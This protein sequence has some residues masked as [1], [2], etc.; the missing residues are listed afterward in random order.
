MRRAYFPQG[1]VSAMAGSEGRASTESLCAVHR[2]VVVPWELEGD[3]RE[4]LGEILSSLRRGCCR[5][6]VERRRDGQPRCKVALSYEDAQAS[7]PDMFDSDGYL[8]TLCPGHAEAVLRLFV[9]GHVCTGPHCGDAASGERALPQLGVKR[10]G[11]RVFCARCWALV[12]RRGGVAKTPKKPLRLAMV[13]E[14]EEDDELDASEASGSTVFVAPVAAHGAVDVAD[15]LLDEMSALTLSDGSSVVGGRGA[16]DA[17][18]AGGAREAVAAA[19]AADGGGAQPASEATAVGEPMPTGL[20]RSMSEVD[21]MSFVDPFAG[22]DGGAFD[23]WRGP[24]T[25][26][27]G[28]GINAGMATTESSPSVAGAALEAADLFTVEQTVGDGTLPAHPDSGAIEELSEVGHDEVS[29]VESDI[30]TAAGT[31]SPP[32][33]PPRRLRPTSSTRC[34]RP[35]CPCTARALDVDVDG[36]VLRVHDFCCRTCATSRACAQNYHRRALVTVVRP[37]APP[38]APPPLVDVGLTAQVETLAQLVARLAEKVD[39]IAVAGAKGSEDLVENAAPP[40]VEDVPVAEPPVVAPAEAQVKLVTLPAAQATATPPKF[41][42]MSPAQ[43]DVAMRSVEQAR[44]DAADAMAAV[45][46]LKGA[47]DLAHEE[48]DPAERLEKLVDLVQN[49]EVDDARVARQLTEKFMEEAER[50]SAASKVVEIPEAD[51]QH[52]MFQSKEEQQM[53]RLAKATNVPEPVVMAPVGSRDDSLLN[54]EP[55]AWL[56]VE[57]EVTRADVEG[58]LKLVEP[59]ARRELGESV[60]EHVLSARCHEVAAEALGVSLS[61]VEEALRSVA[62]SAPA[63]GISMVVSERE[64]VEV[65]ESGEK[66]AANVLS[67]AVAENWVGSMFQAPAERP[68][69]PVE[70]RLEGGIAQLFRLGAPSRSIPSSVSSISAPSSAAP[71]PGARDRFGV[72]LGGGSWTSESVV[73]S[74]PTY[75]EGPSY[76]QVVADEHVG[77]PPPSTTAEIEQVIDHRLHTR[78]VESAENR[79]ITMDV[80]MAVRPLSQMGL[81]DDAVFFGMRGFGRAPS[82]ALLLPQCGGSD[83]ATVDASITVKGLFLLLQETSLRV[84]IEDGESKP[85]VYPLPSLIDEFAAIAFASCSFGLFQ[86]TGGDGESGY[87][88]DGKTLLLADLKRLRLPKSD[89]FQGLGEWVSRPEVAQTFVP[90]TGAAGVPRE[91][92]ACSFDNLAEWRETALVEAQ[93]MGALFHVRHGDERRQAIE[94]IYAFASG[95]RTNCSPV[96]VYLGYERMR[97][98]YMNQ[99]RQHTR[100]MINSLLISQQSI[101]RQHIFNSLKRESASPYLEDGQRKVWQFP[102]IFLN[103]GSPDGYFRAVVLAK[104][105]QDG[106]VRM[107]A[108][109][110][111]AYHVA[112]AASARRRQ[113]DRPS[114]PAR[115]GAETSTPVYPGCWFGTSYAFTATNVRLDPAVWKA[116]ISEWVGLVRSSEG[117]SPVVLCLAHCCF[118]GCG[119]GE[120]KCVAKWTASNCGIRVKHGSCPPKLATRIQTDPQLIAL[121]YVVIRGGGLKGFDTQVQPENV[122]AEL[123]TL[124]PAMRAKLKL[125]GSGSAPPHRGESEESAGAGLAAAAEAQVMREWCAASL[126]VQR[127]HEQLPHELVEPVGS[128]VAAGGVEVDSAPHAASDAAFQ[129]MLDDTAMA[130][131]LY[132]A[133]V[134]SVEQAEAFRDRDLK[135]LTQRLAREH[136]VFRA[137]VKA[138]EQ[139]L[140]EEAAVGDVPVAAAADAQSE[141]PTAPATQVADEERDVRRGRPLRRSAGARGGR[142][143]AR[144]TMRLRA[145]TARDAGVQESRSQRTTSDEAMPR[146]S[147]SLGEVA[148]AKT[149]TSV[150]A[151]GRGGRLAPAVLVEQARDAREPEL[152]E[153][154]HGVVDDSLV[155]ETATKS[156]PPGGIPSEMWSVDDTMDVDFTDAVDAIGTW[157]AEDAHVMAEWSE[158]DDDAHAYVRSLSA[159][160]LHQLTPAVMETGSAQS[161]YASVQGDVLKAVARSSEESRAAWAAARIAALSNDGAVPEPAALGRS[162]Q[163]VYDNICPGRGKRGRV[164][165]LGREYTF[166]DLGEMLSAAEGE[167]PER[168]KCFFLATARAVKVDPALLLYQVRVLADEYVKHGPKPSAGGSLPDHAVYCD[169]L[170]HDATSR[171]HSQYRGLFLFLAPELLSDRQVVYISCDAGRLHVEVVSGMRY[172]GGATKRGFVLCGSGH[173]VHLLVEAMSPPQFQAWCADVYEASGNDPVRLRMLGWRRIFAASAHTPERVKMVRVADLHPCEQCPSSTAPCVRWQR[174]AR[175]RRADEAAAAAGAEET[176]FCPYSAMLPE[177]VTRVSSE[178]FVALTLLS[179]AREVAVLSA[180]SQFYGRQVVDEGI[181]DDILLMPALVLVG[182]PT[183]VVS[184]RAAGDTVYASTEIGDVHVRGE[185]FEKACDVLDELEKSVVEEQVE[186]LQRACEAIESFVAGG[187]GSESSVEVGGGSSVGEERMSSKRMAMTKDMEDSVREAIA[188]AKVPEAVAAKNVA[189]LVDLLVTCWRL[190]DEKAA[191]QEICIRWAVVAEISNELVKLLGGDYVEAS[192]L[193]GA[194]FNERF[195]DHLDA[196]RIRERD[197][198]T[199]ELRD[200]LA[201]IAEVGVEANERMPRWHLRHEMDKAVAQEYGFEAVEKMVKDGRNGRIFLMSDAV[202]D[203]VKRTAIPIM[204]CKM[205]RVAKRFLSGAVDPAN[206]RFCHAMIE[207]NLI[208]P[209]KGLGLHGRV[210]LPTLRDVLADVFYFARMYPGLPIFQRKSDVD[211]AFKLL[212][213]APVLVGLFASSVPAWV[214]GLGLGQ[215][216][217]LYRCLTFGSAISPASYDYFSKGIEMLHRAYRPSH[218]R[219]DGT[220]RFRNHTLV[221][222]GVVTQVFLGYCLRQSAALYE[223]AMKVLLGRRAVNEGKKLEEGLWLQRQIDWGILLDISHAHVDPESIAASMT[224][225]KREKAK[226]MVM[227]PM[228]DHGSY[229]FGQWQVKVLAGNVMFWAT[230]CRALWPAAL[231]LSGAIGGLPTGSTG[232][233]PGDAASRAAYEAV[234]QWAEV[235]RL[236]VGSP[237]WW[238]STFAGTFLS[239]IPLHERLRLPS[240]EDNIVWTGGDANLNGVAAGS[241]TDG[242]YFVLQTAEWRE[243]LLVIAPDAADPKLFVAIWELLCFVC[244]A[245]LLAADWEGKIVLYVSDNTNTVSWLT[246]MRSG[247]KVANWLLLIMVLMT[248]RFRFETFSFYVD[249]EANPWDWPSRIFDDDSVRKGRGVDE[250]EEGMEMHFPGMEL[251]DHVAALDHYLRPGGVMNALELFGQ[252]DEVARSLARARTAHATFDRG[253]SQMVAVGF[254]AGTGGFESCVVKRGATIRL[255]VEWDAGARALLR[256]TVGAVQHVVDFNSEDHQASDPNGVVLATNSASCQPYSAAGQQRGLD[257]PRGWQVVDSPRKYAHFV[258]LLVTI[259]ENVWLL[260]YANGG[261][262]WAWYCEGMNAIQHDVYPPERVNA[263][264]LG[265]GVR[266]D[267]CLA[268]SERRPMGKYLRARE[269]LSQVRKPAVPIS[270]FLLPY[271]VVSSRRRSCEVHIASDDVEWYPTEQHSLRD[272]LKLGRVWYSGK[273]KSGDLLEGALVSFNGVSRKW[274]VEEFNDRGHARVWRPGQE[275]WVD[276]SRVMGLTTHGFYVDIYSIHAAGVGITAMGEKPAGPGK[277]IYLEDR[278]AASGEKWFRRLLPE[279][280]W[281]VLGKSGEVLQQWRRRSAHEAREAHLPRTVPP[282]T[283]ANV[284][285]YS[286]IS[287]AAGVADLAVSSSMERIAEYQRLVANGSAEAPYAFDS[288]AVALPPEAQAW[289]DRVFAAHEAHRPSEVDRLEDEHLRCKPSGREERADERQDMS[290]EEALRHCEASGAYG[291]L[292]SDLDVDEC[293]VSAA[294]LARI[295]MACRP[296]DK[297]GTA[298]PWD[299]LGG[300]ADE[301]MRQ[302]RDDPSADTGCEREEPPRTIDEA[303]DRLGIAERDRADL[304]TYGRWEDSL[305][306]PKVSLAFRK[307]CEAKGHTVKQVMNKLA[308]QQERV[309][310]AA[311]KEA[312]AEE[313]GGVDLRGSVGVAPPPVAEAKPEPTAAQADLRRPAKSSPRPRSRTRSPGHDAR[314]RAKRQPT[315]RKKFARKGLAL[316]AMEAKQALERGNFDEFERF[317]TEELP[318]HASGYRTLGSYASGW[319]Q[320]I[321]FRC[322]TKEPVFLETE[323]GAQRR[324]A[325]KALLAFMGI[326]AFV[327]GQRAGTIKGKLMAVRYFHLVH[328]YDNPLDKC[329]RIWMAYRAIKRT[330]DPTERKYPATPEMMDYLDRKDAGRGLLGIA[331]RATRYLALFFACRCSE[332]L[333]PFDWDKVILVGDISPM[334]GRS[335][336][337]WEDDFDGSMVRFRSSKTDKYNEGCLRYVGRA[338]H[339]TRCLIKALHEWH[340]ADPD[341]FDQLDVPLVQWSG[342]RKLTRTMVQEELREAAV[343]CHGLPTK[344]IGTHSLRVSY[345]TWMYQANVDVEKIKRHGRWTSDAVH[346]YFWEGSGHMKDATTL[347]NVDFT[348]H[349]MAS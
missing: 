245:S 205:I 92:V 256:I 64:K 145:A 129:Q 336:C 334:S 22:C 170:A 33:G 277:G 180:A 29:V 263:V 46:T 177:A 311:R 166:E 140:S 203:L 2:L 81:F 346:F 306:A 150:F 289:R 300:L 103:A 102:S 317:A 43:R 322:G 272:P 18:G 88:Y 71:V 108:A 86:P 169:E 16:P 221:D 174:R 97:Y 105:F 204:L 234:W 236:I 326:D 292:E 168:A 327:M 127:A 182:V 161:A 44:K 197:E 265:A 268:V 89:A 206:G 237:R 12:E 232:K 183:N 152:E 65:T 54:K 173:A 186:P 6:K 287:I 297:L 53:S 276:L 185:E 259:L 41:T 82:P 28:A 1:C 7:P 196:S 109:G 295:P 35:G 96:L 303:W 238:E 30:T 107:M 214:L 241:W 142:G 101:S 13:D 212:W 315:K 242:R 309:D 314:V 255:A 198:L 339:P 106:L 229:E 178:S 258:H 78:L 113:R 223:W 99:M 119:D 75:V 136:P 243:R 4:G 187:D 14:Q 332:Y 95:T 335:Y 340:D 270:Q 80:H 38:L 321:A 26:A 191:K 250:L 25:N 318:A 9:E 320:W 47:D 159:L 208:T 188:Q 290:V 121:R 324:A 190:A 225:V 246:R 143:L 79:T 130:D 266:R 252:H 56:N 158:L 147:E 341:H 286:G 337:N 239:L 31:G 298:G 184:K 124:E 261:K 50:A 120:E 163:V 111:G 37:V 77:A 49:D 172:T 85:P 68:A 70:R 98:D 244:L 248:A 154:L 240:A 63:A 8:C 118:A 285:H 126:A 301:V 308:D 228:W 67:T 36:Q 288:G 307:K 94:E 128:E 328:G 316:I 329:P 72:P 24:T 117:G 293:V 162:T 176:A 60:S 213:L 59:R 347:A 220:S 192:R 151:R 211:A 207:A 269:S 87:T 171:D 281:H 73:S 137:D 55:V 175:R 167:T 278:G 10:Q 181:I 201:R 76:R 132:R 216:F 202:N 5:R 230:V 194:K 112:V 133:D 90:S 215:F 218:P 51:V 20:S 294:E 134:R 57:P 254:F 160:L 296:S 312:Q 11:G 333:A 27:S 323:T 125:G 262:A 156:V 62:P 131:G 348:L 279:E 39:A 21:E 74:R 338:E 58:M 17:T 114:T 217:V 227:D 42:A 299:R 3:V 91:A 257:D 199:D 189:A 325:T 313:R 123:A 210:A 235:L 247:C 93:W 342:G 149:R 274:R 193:F 275:Q 19:V 330:E 253:Y 15:S 84:V 141:V 282:Y 66:P 305:G 271:E 260:V 264:N 310:A 331:L 165:I 224:L 69:E 110:P 32:N 195:G 104:Y 23:A 291:G 304:P 45:R 34:R 164:S 200:R 273:S 226:T 40:V 100:R 283:A 179:R 251:L 146:I 284:H 343:E 139:R 115:L 280:C 135:E 144:Q 153:A 219:R 52:K 345:A 155:V 116:G 157:L 122:S 148:E 267:R 349:A 249:T 138:R 319:R 344:R 61:V 48:G 231:G 209:S 83:G 233:V 302:I 222:D